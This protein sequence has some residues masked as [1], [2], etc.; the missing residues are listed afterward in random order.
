M[1]KNNIKCVQCLECV[2]ITA[3]EQKDSTPGRTV[4]RLVPPG[5]R[6]NAPG[7]KKTGGQKSWV[8]R[9]KSIFTK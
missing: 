9:I 1:K 7:D 2:V 8:D 5:R 6:E 4:C 3:G